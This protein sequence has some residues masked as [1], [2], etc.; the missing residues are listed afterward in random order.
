MIGEGIVAVGSSGADPGPAGVHQGKL[1]N[2]TAMATGSCQQFSE[3]P[4]NPQGQTESVVLGSLLSVL[5]IW[6]QLPG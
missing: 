3:T 1:A 5:I 4:E 6:G 2:N